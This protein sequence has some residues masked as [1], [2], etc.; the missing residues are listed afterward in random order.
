MTREEFEKKFPKSEIDKMIETAFQLLRKNNKL[1]LTFT[2]SNIKEIYDCEDG[3][4]TCKVEVYYFNGH[5]HHTFELIELVFDRDH[6]MS[7]DQ[8]GANNVQDLRQKIILRI[9]WRIWRH[10]T[11]ANYH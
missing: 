7:D 2:H 11:G 8:N 1:N 3:L 6:I 9:A 5:E 10:E 4:T